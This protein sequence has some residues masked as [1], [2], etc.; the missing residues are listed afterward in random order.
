MRPKWSFFDQIN[1]DSAKCKQCGKNFLRKGGGTT[2]LQLHFKSQHSSKYDELILLE[3]N[4][5]QKPLTSKQLT[6]LQECK[7]Q[8]SLT[9]SLKNK[10]AWD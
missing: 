9:D 3:K 10:S 1:V 5:Q 4:N 7:K 2:S 8:L 6:P